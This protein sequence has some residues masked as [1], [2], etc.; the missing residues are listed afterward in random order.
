MPPRLLRVEKVL[1][2]IGKLGYPHDDVLDRY[3]QGWQVGRR[4]RP[5]VE[6]HFWWLIAIEVIAAVRPRFPVRQ[7]HHNDPPRPCPEIVV[8]GHPEPFNRG[9]RFFDVV[10]NVVDVIDEIRGIDDREQRCGVRALEVRDSGKIVFLGSRSCLFQKVDRITVGTPI[11]GWNRH[12]HDIGSV[13]CREKCQRA[14]LVDVT[15]ENEALFCWRT[16]ARNGNREGVGN[17][18]WQS[19]QPVQRRD[20]VVAETV[21]GA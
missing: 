17:D 19:I 3:T 20:H 16:G 21:I 12:I 4:Q 9:L 15:K 10:C 1:S 5:L 14:F 8:E 18:T 13:R 6:I 11:S 2:I 7:L